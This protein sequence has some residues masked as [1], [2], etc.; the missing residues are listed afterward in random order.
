[1]IDIVVTT[2]ERLPLLQ[3]TLA[4]IWQRTV[5]PYRLRVVDDVSTEGNA[6]YL[7]AEYAA[8]RVAS[9][10]L[11]RRRVGIASHLRALE[12]I[13]ASDPVVVTDDDV[14]C[15]QLEPDWLARGLAAL[16]RFPD[17]GLLALNNPQ[18]N[19]DGS[20]GPKTTM[21]GVT[22]CRN[23]GATFLFVRRAVLAACRVADGERSPVKRLCLLAAAAGWQVGYLSDVYCQHIG[24]VS[25]RTRHDLSAA[26]ALVAPVNPYT[27]EPADEYKG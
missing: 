16:E 21:G 9:I 13:T 17:L 22:L 4:H 24:S 6:E 2:C 11:H 3:Q 26:L 7:R 20:R 18:C 15:P 25:V 27:L 19:L 23:V 14:L 5:T 12:Q 8:G 1:M 10:H